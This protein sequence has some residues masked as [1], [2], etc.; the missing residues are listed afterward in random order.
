MKR[1]AFMTIAAILALIVGL[2]FALIP[3]QLLSIYSITLEPDGEWIARCLGSVFLGV[4]V[5][6]WLGR[7]APQGVAL[8]AI[9]TGDFVLSVTGLIMAILFAIRGSGNALVWSTT[10]VYALLT[11]GFGYYRFVKPDSP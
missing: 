9:M 11:A 4:A 3:A 5:T 2:A 6:T 10:I 1:S 7:N 8:S